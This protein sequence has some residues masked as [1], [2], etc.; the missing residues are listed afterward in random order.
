MTADASASDRTGDCGAGRP[1]FSRAQQFL[2]ARTS[3]AEVKRRP[4]PGSELSVCRARGWHASAACVDRLPLKR[5]GRF[6][7]GGVEFAA[8]VRLVDDSEPCN[9]PRVRPATGLRSSTPRALSSARNGMPRGRS[10]RVRATSSS[11]WTSDPFRGRP[12][13]RPDA[14]RVKPVAVDELW[15]R[16]PAINPVVAYSRAVA[17][18][19]NSSTE[20]SLRSLA[21]SPLTL[22]IAADVRLAE[23]FPIQSFYLA[24]RRHVCGPRQRTSIP[25]ASS[26][27]GLHQF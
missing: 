5:L 4:K 3:R 2:L 17:H 7:R 11:P 13:L 12:P 9:L 25:G 6:G 18:T 22:S 10:A 14:P 1:V 15:D 19:T 8:N 23:L 21:V 20:Q 26:S 27:V 16:W 24:R